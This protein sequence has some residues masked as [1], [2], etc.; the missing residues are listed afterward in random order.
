[1][2]S[3]RLTELMAA[4]VTVLQ[5]VGYEALT[6]D[7][8]AARARTSKATLY[9]HWGSKAGL[10]MAALTHQPHERPTLFEFPDATSLDEVFAQLAQAGRVPDRDLRVAFMV[11]QAA[12]SDPDFGSA[13][14]EQIIAPLVDGL[15]NVFEA[16]ADRGEIVRDS[17][18]FHRLAYLIVADIVF[19]PLIS[20][21]E[22][23]SSSR[24]ELFRAIVR[25]ALTFTDHRSH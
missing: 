3:E 19:F 17:P 4:V 15:A 8:V 24:E 2:S 7:A 21:R 11:L 22:E 23:D 13:L 18:L 1:M 6:F 14:R 5:D 10:V 12:S 9:K 25:P 20:G 16:A